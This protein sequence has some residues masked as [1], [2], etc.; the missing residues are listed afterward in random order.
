MCFFV[1]VYVNI[2]KICQGFEFVLLYE[3]ILHLYFILNFI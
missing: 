3:V 1:R 2:A